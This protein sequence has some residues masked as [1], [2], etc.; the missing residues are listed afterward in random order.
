MPP[1]LWFSHHSADP[2]FNMGFDE[3]MM[4]SALAVPGLLIVRLYTWAG[5]GAITFGRNQRQQTALNWDEVGDTPVI[6]RITGG[7]AVYHDPGELTYSIAVNPTTPERQHLGGSIAKSSTLFS[8]ALHDFARQQGVPT[9]V[10]T[11]STPADATPA[12]FHKA[13]CF[14]SAARHELIATDRK[15]VAS[16]QRQVDGV[17][18]QHGSIKLHGL[19]SHPALSGVGLT[20][21]TDVARGVDRTAWHQIEV[22]F[23][24]IM[25]TH[26]EAELHTRDLSP[27]AVAEIRRMSEA[28]H[29]DPFARRSPV[30]QTALANSL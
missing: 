20:G 22:S 3:W 25:G 21:Q 19:A 29:A 24:D 9:D 15:I 18:L 17:I 13:P 2:W 1:S 7:R 16:A 8:K 11:R 5:A 30:K 27:T 23:R 26:L 10:V 14:A 12:I 28:V 4:G 6:R